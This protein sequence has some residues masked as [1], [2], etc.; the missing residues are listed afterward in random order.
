MATIT[1]REDRPAENR[2]QA[3]VRRKGFPTQSKSFPT[4]AD[5]EGWA[6][7]VEADMR[8]GSFVDTSKARDTTIGELLAKY[9]ECVSPTKKSGDGEI[10]R[11]RSMQSWPLCQF[12]AASVMPEVLATWRDDRLKEVSGSTV[13]RELNL[14]SHVFST[15]MIEWRIHLPVSRIRRPRHNKPR[16]RRT[17]GGKEALLLHACR[18]ARNKFLYPAVLLA[19]ETGMRRSEVVG[20]RWPNI[21]L[22]KQTLWL[23]DS[24]NDER[25]AVAL[26]MRA[27]KALQAIGTDLAGP[28]FPGLTVEAVKCAYRRARSR[29]NI[30][31]LRLHDLRHEATSRMFE[32]GLNA[33]EVASITGHKT[34]SMLQRYTHLRAEDL[35][36]K[37]G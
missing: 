32:K 31:D 36:K 18:K 3:K 10:K 20:I 34:L 5:A 22:D 8:H 15:A 1:R 2:W 17:E 16:S 19:I 29:A 33:M 6:L 26:S 7:G 23:P 13:N 4:K 21:N 27:V 28:V 11:I 37:L 14:L 25:R 9:A 30:D 35:A 12:A 24:K